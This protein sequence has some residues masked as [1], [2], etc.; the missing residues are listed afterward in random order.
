MKKVF[1]HFRKQISISE[2]TRKDSGKK[3]QNNVR[4]FEK[5]E[6]IYQKKGKHIRKTCMNMIPKCKH[7]ERKH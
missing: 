5:N 2:K 6:C 4:I 7:L 1:Q 3:N